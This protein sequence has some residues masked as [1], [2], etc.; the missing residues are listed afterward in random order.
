MSSRCT[1][2]YTPTIYLYSCCNTGWDIFLADSIADEKREGFNNDIR[3]GHKELRK[4]Y[5][6]LK[7]Y[8]ESGAKYEKLA[9]EESE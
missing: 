7:E 1:I 4:L 6:E 3:I 8:F 2:A 9:E 5:E